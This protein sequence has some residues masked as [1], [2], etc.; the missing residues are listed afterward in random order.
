MN[1]LSL[2]MIAHVNFTCKNFK[3]LR[4]RSKVEKNFCLTFLRALKGKFKNI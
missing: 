1:E 3:D 4:A 2:A